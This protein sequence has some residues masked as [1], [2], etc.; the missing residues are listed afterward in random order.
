M[1]K[2]ISIIIKTLIVLCAATGVYLNIFDN[3]D[4][5]RAWNGLLYFTVQSNIWMA[6]V[7]AIGIYRILNNKCNSKLWSIVTLVFTISITL[8]G[9][10]FCFILAPTIPANAFVL[11]SVLVHVCVPLLS[12]I[13]LFVC[14]KE[15][16]LKA[17]DAVWVLLPPLY[18]L[19]FASV[20]YVCKWNFGDGRNYPYFFMD[21]SNPQGVIKYI[22]ALLAALWLFGLAY[23]GIVNLVKKAIAQRS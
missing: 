22:C 2:K 3:P 21:W 19:G 11:G 1:G 14:S 12:V 17:K 18:Y 20:G 13:D 5:G 9:M 15:L 16:T 8:T 7:A 6:I 10:V 4:S 23:V